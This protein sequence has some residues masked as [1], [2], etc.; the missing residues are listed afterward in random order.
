MKNLIKMKRFIYALSLLVC[1]LGASENVWGGSSYYTQLTATAAPEGYGKVYVTQSTEDSDEDENVFYVPAEDDFSSHD[2]EESE[3][4]EPGNGKWGYMTAYATAER[5]YK[6]STWSD[7]E[8]NGT[9]QLLDCSLTDNPI[10]VKMQAPTSDGTNEATIVANF[11]ENTV[12]TWNV[13][14]VDS[15]KGKGTYTVKYELAG[16]TQ[17]TIGGTAVETYDNDQ[18]TLN[19]TAANGYVFYRYVGWDDENNKYTIGTVAAA[20]QTTTIPVGTIKVSAEYTND[21]LIAGENTYSDLKDAVQ[22]LRLDDG[23]YKGTIIVAQNFTV[24]AGYY[25]IPK[26]V[27]LIV[28]RNAGHAKREPEIDRKGYGNENQATMP[29]LFRALKL[30]EGVTIDLFGA[31]EVGGSQNIN[32]QGIQTYR[33][34]GNPCNTYGQL[35]MCPNSKIIVEAKGKLRAWGY[36]TGD[37]ANKDARDSVPCGEIDVR[38]GGV[39]KEQFQILDWKGGTASVR[40]P[41]TGMMNNTE[42]V[43]QVNQYFIQN[44]EVPTTYHPGSKLLCSTG[45]VMSRSDFRCND[46]GIVGVEYNEN[47]KDDAMFLMSDADDSKDT[48]V[49]KYYDPVHD[50]QV[51]EINNSA[52]LGNLLITMN[53]YSLQS[54]NYILPITNNMHIH[55]LSGMMEITQSTELLPGAEIEVDK[56]ATVT[57]NEDQSLYLYDNLDW[58]QTYAYPSS[59]AHQITYSPVFDANPTSGAATKLCAPNK[60][61]MT[62]NYASSKYTNTV[63]GGTAGLEDAKL[64]IHGTFDVKGYIYTTKNGANICSNNDDAGTILFSNAA[65]SDSTDVWQIKQIGDTKGKT[66]IYT[67]QRSSSAILCNTDGLYPTT[68]TAGT[69]AGKSFCYLNNKWTQFTIDPDSSCFVYDQY[70]TYYAKPGAY[71]AINATKDPSTRKISGNPD[72][73]YSDAAG[74]G[75]LFILMEACQWWE[76]ENIDNLYRCI[77]NGDTTFYYWDEDNEEW[78]EKQYLIKWLNWDGTPVR[79][80]SEIIEYLLPYGSMPKYNSTNPTRSA[81]KDFTY[82][83]VGW[84][85]DFMR[86]TGDQA[87]TAKYDRDTI[88]YAIIFKFVDSYRSGAEIERQQLP[89]DSMPV[90]PTIKR[91]GWYLKWTPSVGPVT[92]N[93]VYEAEWMEELPD[94]YTIT[95]KNY[96]NTVLATT[97]PARDASAETVL[98]DAPTATREA[99]SEYTYN[100]RAWKPTVTSATQDQTYVAQFNAVEKTFAIRFFDEGTTNT[101]K[102]DENALNKQ[103]LTYGATPT[104]PSVSK[105][106][107][108]HTYIPEWVDMSSLT[109]DGEGNITTDEE[110]WVKSVSTV[111]KAADYVVVYRDE[112]NRYTVSA[113]SSIAAGCVISGAGTYDYGTEVELTVTP[114]P[115]YRFLRWNDNN[116]ENPRSFTLE[117]NVSLTAVVEQYISDVVMDENAQVTYSK[118]NTPI[119]NLY[120]SSD[121]TNSSYLNGAENLV[122][123]EVDAVQGQAYFDLTLNTWSRHWNAFAVPFEVDLKNS[124]IVEVKTK[125]GVATNRTL[126]Y[127]RD[128]DIVYYKESVRATSGP[129]YNCWDYVD[130]KNKVLTPGEAYLIAFTSHVGTIRFTGEQ[131]GEHHIKLGTGVEVSYTAPA[132]P[133]DGGWNGIGNPR[134]YHAL[135]NAGVTECQIHNGDTIGSDSYMPYEMTNKKFV[136]GKAAFVKVGATPSVVVERATNQSAIAPQAAPRR[137]KTITTGGDRYTVE[138]M[139]ENGKIADRLFLLIDE[140]KPDEYT[141]GKDLPK[142]GVGSARAQ[143]WVNRYN[144]KLCKNTVAPI[145]NQADYPLGIYAPK[146]GEYTIYIAT[147]TE[148]VE[149]MYLTLDGSAIWNLSEG[150]YTI[151][152]ERGTT[153]HYG[154]RIS[155]KSPQVA[156][157]VDEAVVD[158]HGKTKKVLI[159]DHVYIIRENNVYSIDGQIVK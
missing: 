85:P 81:D 149:A 143:M 108:G 50:K 95:W 147:K 25:T 6:F 5:G 71:V 60:R 42:K 86:V 72:H 33:G 123:S 126:R 63:I 129:S 37:I 89:R 155:A 52:R 153:Y 154:L 92:G 120:I 24:Q 107:T 93:A 47:N 122:L 36:I 45:M 22:G 53:D 141:D 3:K 16:A 124:S 94:Y 14:Y 28:P 35:I 11:V 65:P 34:V 114:N 10:Q 58:E 97:T 56:K 64:N 157:G 111:T 133:K 49:R 13:Q 88:K 100:F 15:T 144:A 117:S 80:G 102:S 77:H 38:R 110:D 104:P 145:D 131:D 106:A 98:A 140:D 151:S 158:A 55:L 4:Y 70:D 32:G 96:D 83:F 66:M 27:T 148:G 139:P 91:T 51:Y 21:P 57:I 152:L 62:L 99:N 29:S 68:T 112:I 17:P 159:N 127:G 18:V 41:Q 30:S 142:A 23:S 121:G 44:I 54:K 105:S 101:T 115:G 19:A 130:S 116:T 69:S 132:D 12:P 7:L 109:F 135:L 2:V 150:A 103:N 138:I 119:H 78:A 128:Y 136:V 74:T 75:R 1:L 118:P 59:W 73:T 9:P 31:I 20:S 84:T 90:I 156:T 125:G 113:S 61:N 82:S 87:Y 76:V 79:N 137:A 40:S 146:T 39:V 48:W 134:T 43:F 26:N 67:T 46:L 8:G